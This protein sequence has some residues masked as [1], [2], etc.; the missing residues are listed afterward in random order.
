MIVQNRVQLLHCLVKDL[1][2]IKWWAHKRFFVLR[3]L[4]TLIAKNCTALIVIS[5]QFRDLYLRDRKLAPD[6]VHVVPN[7]ID[8]NELIVDPPN[9]PIREQYKFRITHSWS[10][11]AGIS[12]KQQ[13]WIV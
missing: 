11:T 7:W 3:M 4:D 2:S 6:K 9:N 13:M 10:F 5:D 8:E 1:M 12:A